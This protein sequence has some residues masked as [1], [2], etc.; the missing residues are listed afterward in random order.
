MNKRILVVSAHPDD[1]L[2]GVGGTIAKHTKAGDEVFGCILG[3]GAIARAGADMHDVE[4]LKSDARSA[5]AVVGLKNIVF[6]GLPDNA[7]DSIPLL[8]IVREV[9]KVVAEVK[10]DIIYTHHANDLNVDHR[11]AFQAV[12]TAC[13]PCNEHCPAEIYTFETLSSTEWQNKAEAM[14]RPSVYHDISNEIDQKIAALSHYVGEMRV[15]PHSRSV[16]GVR[17]LAQYRGLE[18]GL[19]YAEAFQLVRKI[20]R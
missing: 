13:R 2:L 14:F 5:G 1:E 6:A 18:A 17:I 20:E 8:Q 7:F 16:E 12:L 4:K 19:R 15:Y 11:L 9:E 10:P 3:Q